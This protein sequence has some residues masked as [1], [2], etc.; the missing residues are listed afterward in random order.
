MPIAFFVIKRNVSFHRQTR[1]RSFS[2][3]I[4]FENILGTET[5]YNNNNKKN[6]NCCIILGTQFVYEQ[7]F[8]RP[9]AVKQPLHCF[10]QKSMHKFKCN[11]HCC[12]LALLDIRRSSFGHWFCRCETWHRDIGFYYHHS[13]AVIVVNFINIYFNS[14]QSNRNDDISTNDKQRRTIRVVVQF[15]TSIHFV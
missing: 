15:C 10:E 6:D 1:A 13:N 14:M 8:Q 9:W 3:S 11:A 5:K 12:I 4:T 7:H 2:V